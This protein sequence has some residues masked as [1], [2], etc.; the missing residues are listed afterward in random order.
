MTHA[1]LTVEGKALEVI[2]ASFRNNV[3]YTATVINE[4]GNVAC[5][6]DVTYSPSTVMQ[7]IAIDLPAVFSYKYEHVT[8]IEK[9]IDAHEE[10][11]V[12]LAFEFIQYDTPFAE[13]HELQKEFH[14]LSEQAYGLYQSLN[15]I[16]GTDGELAMKK[17]MRNTVQRAVEKMKE[18]KT[19]AF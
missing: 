13:K 6:H 7:S 14:R 12:E 3:P 10:K 17:L 18:E 11:M 16:D 8:L 15:I 2:N 5:Y 1:I 19:N 9:R 4:E